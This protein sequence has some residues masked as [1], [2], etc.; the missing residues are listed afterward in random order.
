VYRPFNKKILYKDSQLRVYTA[1][2]NSIDKSKH[3]RCSYS[4]EVR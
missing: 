1:G 3:E 2:E 4:S